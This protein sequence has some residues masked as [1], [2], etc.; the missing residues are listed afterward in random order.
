MKT[1]R[2]KL[3]S[4]AVIVA[5][6]AP[7]QASSMTVF[8]PSNFSQNMVTAA[9]SI[10]AE[11]DRAMQIKH[12]LDQYN[13][14]L[15]QAKNLSNV[16]SLLKNAAKEELAVSEYTR[17]LHSMYG[18]VNQS[19]SLF[20]Q[21]YAIS[22]ADGRKV[23]RDWAK[24]AEDNYKSAQEHS[25]ALQQEVRL[26]EALEDNQKK[27][28]AMQ[29]NIP[30]IDSQQQALTQMN[31]QLA[32]LV[33]QQQQ[34]MS[35]QVA[36]SRAQRPDQL[37]GISARTVETERLG[38]QQKEGIALLRSNPEFTIPSIKPKKMSTGN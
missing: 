9:R 35:Y 25:K 37:V 27:I 7:F 24:S 11:Y 6:F 33:Q 19:R 36:M 5:L 34:Y 30:G 17:E 2:T 32:M 20:E 13:E 1:F 10:K 18:N 26:Q 14:M 16:G 22:T 3:T 29:A 12:Q 23:F 38:A 21:R 28:T 8:D 31:A 15:R 4:A